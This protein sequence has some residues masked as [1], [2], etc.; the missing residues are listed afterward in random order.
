MHLLGNTISDEPQTV[1]FITG[2]IYVRMGKLGY[3]LKSLGWRVVLLYSDMSY[4]KDHEKCFD[5]MQYYQSPEEALNIAQRYNPLVYHV[6]SVWEYDVAKFLINSGV[7]LVVLDNYDYLAGMLKSEFLNSRY[8]GLCE[9]ERFCIESAD[10]LCCRDLQFSY[11]RRT[12]KY[13]LKGETIFF[14]EYCWGATELNSNEMIPDKKEIH[15]VYAGNMNIE[16]RCRGDQYQMQFKNGFFL[17]FGRD[18]A[19]AGFHFHL[20]PGRNN[21]KEE[22]FENEFSEYLEAEASSS[23]FHIHRSI[24]EENLIEEMSAYD[25][26]IEAG[27]L[28]TETIGA[29]HSLPIRNRYGMSSKLFGYLDAGLGM[30]IGDNFKM[31]RWMFERYGIVRT[32]YLDFVKEELLATPSEFYKGLRKRVAIARENYLVTKHAPRLAE[33]YFSV[34]NSVNKRIFQ[35]SPTIQSIPDTLNSKDGVWNQERFEKTLKA[36]ETIDEHLSNGGAPSEVLSLVTQPAPGGNLKN[37]E[38]TSYAHN[39]EH[40]LT[41]ISNSGTPED[42]STLV[43][44]FNEFTPRIFM[45]ES[46]LACNLR[47]PECAIGGKLITRKHQILSFDR[48]KILADKIRPYAQFLYPYIWGEPTLNPDIIPILRYA[49]SFTATNISTNGMTMTENLAEDLITSG[50]SSIIVSI[51]GF[52]QDVYGR[53]RIGGDVQK[54]WTALEVL[55][56]YNLKHGKR[57]AIIPQY[58]V[59]R[60]NQHEMGQFVARCRAIGL[61]A[62]FKAP[63]LRENSRFEY[64]D[65]TE[66]IRTHY[67]TED[68]LKNAMRDCPDARYTFTVLVDGS[69]VAC[70]YDHNEVTVFGNLFEQEVEEIWNSPSY[71]QFRWDMLSGNAPQFCTENCLAY[72]KG[73]PERHRTKTEEFA[74]VEKPTCSTS[75]SPARPEDSSGRVSLK[76]KKNTDFPLDD[77]AAALAHARELFQKSLH[78]DAF[79]LYERLVQFWPSHAVSLLAEVYDLYEALPDKESRF[80]LYQARHFDFDIRSGDKVLDVG[81]GHLPFAFATHLTDLSLHDG[82]VGRAG[83]PFKYQD[84]KPVFECNIEQ[85]PFE[86]KEF[87]FVYCSHV[88]EH[89]N[90]PEAACREIMRVGKRGYIET[91]SRGKDIWLSMAKAGNHRWTVEWANDILIFT[92]YTPEEKKGF[93]CDIL[94]NMHCSPQTPREKAFS[95]L[96]YLKATLVNTM[97]CWDESFR[98]EV[99]RCLPPS[100]LHQVVSGNASWQKTLDS[101]CIKLYAGDISDIQH[102]SDVIGLSLTNNDERHIKHDITHPMPLSDNSVDSYQAEDVFEHI[103]YDRL[104]SVVNEI[105][106]VLKLGGIFRLSVPDYGCDVLRERSVKNTFGEIVFDPGGGG[107]K[108]NPGHVWFPRI[109]TIR[110]LI[111]RTEFGRHG[112]VNYLHYYRMDDSFVAKSVDYSKGHVDRTPDFDERVKSPYR[113]MSMIIDLV[114]VP[115]P[116]SETESSASVL[117]GPPQQAKTAKRQPQLCVFLNTYYGAFLNSH[118]ARQQQLHTAGYAEQKKALQGTFFGDSDFYSSGLVKAGWRAEDLVINCLPLQRAWARENGFTGT[119]TEITIEQLRRLRPDVVYLQDMSVASREFLEKIQPLTALI[120][121]QIA[122]PL[123]A[124]AFVEGFDIIISSFPHF[125]KRFRDMGVTS[126]YQPLAFYPSV[127]MCLGTSR[128]DVGVSF[129]GGISGVHGKGTQLLEYLASTTPIEF[130]GYGAASLPPASPVRA[131]HHGEVWGREMF[132]TLARSAITINRHIDVAENFANNMRLFEATG[133]GTLLITD[134]KDNLNE[135]YDIGKEVVAYRSPEECATLTKYYIEHPD[136]AQQIAKAGQARTL[137][138]HTYEKRMKHTAELMERHLRYKGEFARLGAPD[139]Q[140]ISTGF[141]AVKKSQVTDS[142][143]AGWQDENIPRRQRALVQQQLD[144]MYKGKPQAIYQVLAEILRPYIYPGCP[145]LEIGCASGY[146]YEI[147]EYMLG[148]RIAYTGA[149]YSDPLIKMARDYYP[150][151]D[152]HATD[153]AHLPF[154][155]KQFDI[156]IS[157]CVLLHVPNFP[158]HIKEAV[159]VSSNLVVAHRTPVCR[160]RPTQYYRKMAYGVETFEMRFN[161]DEIV[162]AFTSNGLD[163]IKAFEYETNTAHDVFDL[164][165]L[166]K[167]KG[168]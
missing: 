129:V 119:D 149:D 145:I 99:R 138:D 12:L 5:D 68:A 112:T 142:M 39:A 28:E 67:S 132:H 15:V 168:H 72:Y 30:I 83:A 115:A 100:I 105:F 75:C 162:S 124:Q 10:G 165:Y 43:Q 125:V 4:I 77:L 154:E 76:R 51:D 137:R 88:L 127:L 95:A 45:I 159:R 61:E 123:P 22:N 85:M 6:F 150:N 14:P 107:T 84:G 113:P 66:Y 50:L 120:V 7:G 121:G 11:T 143:L 86:D 27:W 80:Q 131:R 108:E 94:M 155:D 110:N 135:L 29:E 111:E 54:A 59:F 69:A 55:Q 151:A 8:P 136:E 122:S 133:C 63:Y 81:S 20:Y 101:Q 65:Y 71:R 42:N 57:V 109:D 96:I 70:C 44:K 117:P 79:D 53:Y 73:S 146:Y 104:V 118:Y 139:L 128:R 60:H 18:L 90:N 16:K 103:P 144:E 40:G 31:R 32:A 46:T 97:V 126:Y 166:F 62:T 141:A 167:R 23:F 38:R 153:G 152:F 49:S 3:A 74:Q 134:Y 98:F 116:A 19:S 114:K 160:Q 130:W 33:F 13:I 82:T 21:Y 1:V 34:V 164:T 41:E 56:R 47:C 92:E 102:H 35:N 106:R 24:P 2:T 64:S 163:L 148:K 147:L 52:S 26:G 48:F 87:D 158:E 17:D 25:L 36:N 93:G 156:A 78:L 140:S 37:P 58:V 89:V 161:E 9:K 91:P 157:S